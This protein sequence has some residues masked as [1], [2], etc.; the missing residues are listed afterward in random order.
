[1][2]YDTLKAIASKYKTKIDFIRGDEPAYQS[3]RLKG[4]LPDICAHMTVMKF[5]IP[6]LI[7]REITD[8]LLNTKASYN[9]R[10]VIK[11]YE[12]DLYYEEF[13]LGFE[14][15]GIAWHLN[16]KNDLIKSEMIKQRKINVI[17]I[18]EYN[19]SRNY[20]KD[21]K[22]QLINNLSLI[23]SITNKKISKS[24]ILNCKIKNIYLELYNKEEL[25]AIAKSYKLFADFYKKKQNIYRKLCKMGLINIAT[26]HMKDKTINK[27]KFT[28]EYLISIVSTYN[29]LTDFRKNE[30]VIYK[31]IKRVK[32][33][34]LLINLKRKKMFTIDEV[35]NTIKF[36]KTKHEFIISNP[37]MYNFIRRGELQ[38][39]LKTSFN[40][41]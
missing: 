16:N 32:K 4:Y 38:Y 30:P 34:Y 25:I 5:S 13:N 39:L 20:E 2:T 22:E 21:I 1:L 31:H 14:Y 19:G 6:Q 17:Y 8:S 26:S 40:T 23:N 9:N 27:H 35:I 11:P 10:K 41:L 36:H 12:I 33:N 37:K 18:Y 24:K 7:L 28:E 3:A 29:N 15:Q